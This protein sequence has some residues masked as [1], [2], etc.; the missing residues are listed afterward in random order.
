M[1]FILSKVVTLAVTV[2]LLGTVWILRHGGA[3]NGV[4]TVN[5]NSDTVLAAVSGQENRLELAQRM[6]GTISAGSSVVPSGGNEAPKSHD[7]AATSSDSDFEVGVRELLNLPPIPTPTTT[8]R[9][10]VETIRMTP[11]GAKF[12][13][14]AFND[15]GERVSAEEAKGASLAAADSRA[16][17]PRGKKCK[18]CDKKKGQAGGEAPGN[19]PVP[20]RAVRPEA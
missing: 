6:V 18:T 9:S 15:E 14:V 12:E 10:I 5:G 7:A 3:A 20:T 16:T 2:I 11:K 19:S 17:A 13:Y 1:K 4:T 8:E